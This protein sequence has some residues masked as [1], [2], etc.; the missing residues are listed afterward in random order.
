GGPR[1]PWSLPPEGRR[2][3]P[4]GGGGGGPFDDFLRRAR[5]GGFPGL[6]SGGSRIWLLVA[7]GLIAIWLLYT[8]FHIIGPQERGVAT[9]FGRYWSTLQ[10]GINW[11]LPS[12]I[13][14][15]RVIDVQN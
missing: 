4:G 13:M 8:S 5:G 10:P 3:R 14:S 7:G 1:N 9:L 6:P 12:P 2:P 11:T 15:V